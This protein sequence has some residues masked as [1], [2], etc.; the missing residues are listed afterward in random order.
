M[1]E[2][3]ITEGVMQEWV[4]SIDLKLCKSDSIMM[5]IAIMNTHL[6]SFYINVMVNV[7]IRNND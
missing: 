6:S 5:T 4:T 2:G 3:D 1:H 7:S